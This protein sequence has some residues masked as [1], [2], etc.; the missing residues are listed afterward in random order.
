MN[1][2]VKTIYFYVSCGYND[3][4]SVRFGGTVIVGCGGDP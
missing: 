4:W 1:Y 2:L 3:I